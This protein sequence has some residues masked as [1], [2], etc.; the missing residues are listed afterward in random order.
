MENQ[1]IITKERLKMAYKDADEQ[2]KKLLENL[3]IKE[4]ENINSDEFYSGE[5]VRDIIGRL[6]RSCDKLYQKK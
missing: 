6:R 4:Y 2:Q 5:Q 3:F 1:I